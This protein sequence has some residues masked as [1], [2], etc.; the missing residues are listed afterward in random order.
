MNSHS[1]ADPYLGF[2]IRKKREEKGI[3]LTKAAKEMKFSPSLLSQIERGIVAPSLSTLRTIADYLNSTIG[4][5][6]GERISKENAVVTREGNGNRS[7]ILGK[8][9]K[10]NILSPS[11]ANLEFMY[12]EYEVNSCT[13]DK[14]YQHEGEECAFILEGKLEINLNGKKIVLN[15]GDFIWFLST[16]PH[17]IKNLSDKKSLAIWVDSPP[18]F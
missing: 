11:N 16:I 15:K 2:Q 12:D 4:V 9:V 14:L 13:G 18:R 17:K 6:L 7:I 5:L 8:G 10:L 3:T 1:K